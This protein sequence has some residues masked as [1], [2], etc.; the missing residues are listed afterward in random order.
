[1]AEVI[2]DVLG[3]HARKIQL[4]G[5]VLRREYKDDGRILGFPGEMR[6]AILN[7]VG[8]AVEAMPSGGQLTVRLH[9]SINP[10]DGGRRGVRVSVFDTGSGIHP[11][12]RRRI[13]EPF[14]STKDIRGTGLGLWVTQGIIQKHEGNI[15]FRSCTF[16]SGKVTCF[17]IFVP[18]PS[19]PAA[20]KAGRPST[21]MAV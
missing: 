11:E 19:L 17:S 3:M 4:T 7:L 8:N 1:M 20:P 6:Q 10:R 21:P 15:G 9:Q 5:I 12:D 13:F 2:D 18:V 16:S 14:F